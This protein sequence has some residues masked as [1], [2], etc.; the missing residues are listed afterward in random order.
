MTKWNLDSKRKPTG[1][2]LRSHQKKKKYQRGSDFSGTRIAEPVRKTHR[3]RGGGTKVKIVSTNKMNV[4]DEK[5]K[6]S[7]AKIIS[8]KDNKANVHFIRRNLITK[9]AI[10]ET[11]KGLAKVTSR[12]GKDGTVNGVLVKPKK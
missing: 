8:A 4:A 3:V 1:G 11:D 2:K 5:G 12:P 6:I 9:G 10:L 7:V